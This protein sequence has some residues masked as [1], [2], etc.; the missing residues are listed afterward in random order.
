MFDELMYCGHV[1]MFTGLRFSMHGGSL[2]LGGAAFQ[3]HVREE[4]Q[5]AS[6]RSLPWDNTYDTTIPQNMTNM[7]VNGLAVN[8][9]L[10]WWAPGHAIQCY[11]HLHCRPTALQVQ[12]LVRMVS[13]ETNLAEVHVKVCWDGCDGCRVGLLVALP[14]SVIAAY[15]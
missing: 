3:A 10:F 11:T 12:E 7:S 4:H 1:S 8:D 14:P 5:P 15:D 9:F 2:L 6:S 13:E